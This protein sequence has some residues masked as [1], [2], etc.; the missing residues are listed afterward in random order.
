M[1]T[2]NYKVECIIS[3]KPS[4]RDPEGETILRDLVVRSG[5]EGIKNIRAAKLLQMEVSAPSKVAAE[6]LVLKVCDELRIY[7]P[8][9][10]ICTIRVPGN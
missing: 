5:Y 7:N 3:N 9:V 2:A 10:S 1:G 4:I 8:V 6:K